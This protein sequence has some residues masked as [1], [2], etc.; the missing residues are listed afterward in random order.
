MEAPALTRPVP[1]SSEETY[2][3]PKTPPC[4]ACGGGLIELRGF[5]RC[6]RCRYRICEGCEGGYGDSLV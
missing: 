4:P 3:T 6:P 5:W 2:A 1:S